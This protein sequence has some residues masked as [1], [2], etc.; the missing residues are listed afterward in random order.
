MKVTT[1]ITDIKDGKEI[2]RGHELTSLIA[3]RTF[4]ETIFLLLTGKLPSEQQKTMF[5]AMLTAVIDHGPATASAMNARISASASNPVHASLAAGLL[6][7]GERHGVAVSAAMSYFYDTIDEVDLTELLKER[8]E[9][10]RYVPGFGHK[11]LEVDE[12]SEAL[13]EKAKETGVF[14]KHCEFALETERILGE[15]SSKPLPLNVD[16]A[17]A[18]L[19]CDMGFD[20]ELGNAVFIIGR[21]PG[22]LAHII[23]ERANDEGIRR[24]TGDQIQ[25]V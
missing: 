7:L 11:V 17:I 20:S 4:S 21:V 13:L 10:K 25:F 12:R 16:G 3:E 8:K 1:S 14:G 22:L 5:D 6:G 9:E 19:L 15:I 2:V 24:L 18:A 23:E